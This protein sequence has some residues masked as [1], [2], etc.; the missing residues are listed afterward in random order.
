MS[1]GKNK[2]NFPKLDIERIPDEIK[3]IKKREKIILINGI[4]FNG[5]NLVNLLN[6]IENTDG[7]FTAVVINSISLRAELESLGIIK[8]NIRGSSYPGPN[9]S[10][11]L[12]KTIYNLL[13]G[14]KEE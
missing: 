13:E 10:R 1:K 3:I 7:M 14:K 6:D 11:S 12:I 5:A 2:K 9:Y 4:R 8:T